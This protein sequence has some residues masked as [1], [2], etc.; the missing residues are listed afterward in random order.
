M[1]TQ[2]QATAVKDGDWWFVEVPEVGAYGQATS[3]AKAPAVA[4]EVTA[5][6]LDVDPAEVEV[7]VTAQ[8]DPETAA[9]IERADAL[10][11][12]AAA[13]QNKAAELRAA[14]VLRYVNEHHV[15]R[16]EAAAAL[17]MSVQRVQQLVTS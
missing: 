4:R 12:E 9:A 8:P 17:G 1:V 2:Y 7:T 6:W 13:L 5:L 3:L 11:A 14:A 10:A 15:T 16:R